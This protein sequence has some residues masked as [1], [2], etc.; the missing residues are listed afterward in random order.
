MYGASCQTFNMCNIGP[1][2]PQLNQRD[3]LAIENLAQ[4][5]SESKKGIIVLQGGLI[6]RTTAPQCV[7]GATTERGTVPGGTTPCDNVEARGDCNDKDWQ[8][9]VPFAFFKTVIDTGVD[10]TGVDGAVPDGTVETAV[11]DNGNGTGGG[12]GSGSGVGAGS[13]SGSGGGQAAAAASAAASAASSAASSWTFLYTKSQ[14]EIGPQPTC[15]GVCETPDEALVKGPAAVAE[16]VER[17]AGFVAG[18]WGKV[19]DAAQAECGWCGSFNR[20]Y[21]EALGPLLDLDP[22]EREREQ[23]R[24]ER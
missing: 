11:H 17:A 13:G 24:E 8:V 16:R 10:G 3:W 23:E 18:S 4:S 21:W 19:R 7:C 1:Q 5:L 14:S 2:S 15:S 12:F 22:E 9:R 6:S 20:S